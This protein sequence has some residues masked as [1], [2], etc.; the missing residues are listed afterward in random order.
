[1]VNI[2]ESAQRNQRYPQNPA[3]NTTSP[4]NKD[5]NKG[6][7]EDPKLVLSIGIICGSELQI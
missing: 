2:M 1:M 7:P 6:P 3:V 5:V 4:W